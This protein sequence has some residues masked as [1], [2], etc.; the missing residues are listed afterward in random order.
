MTTPQT[1]VVLAVLGLGMLVA[2]CIGDQ[3]F[4]ARA[5]LLLGAVAVLVWWARRSSGPRLTV[6]PRL[7]VV[8][9]VGLSQRAGLA[10]VEVDG[11]PYLIVHGEG[12]ARMRPT[13]KPRMQAVFELHAP[14]GLA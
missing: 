5:M 7:E 10:L 13:R 4:V 12:Y 8:H 3:A 11:Q 2:L 14:R 6:P 9:R 1:R